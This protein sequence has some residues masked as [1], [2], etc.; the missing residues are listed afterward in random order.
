MRGRQL[1]RGECHRTN[2][3]L[4]ESLPYEPTFQLRCRHDDSRGA[5]P[6]NSHTCAVRSERLLCREP[7]V[8]SCLQGMSK[9]PGPSARPRRR[10]DHDERTKSRFGLKP[11]RLVA[12]TAYGSAANFDW[13]VNEKGI[14]PH[15]PV[16]DKSKRSFS[17]ITSVP[18]PA[19]EPATTR[20]GA[21]GAHHGVLRFLRE[22]GCRSNG[23]ELISVEPCPGRA[24]SRPTTGAK[25]P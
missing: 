2:T 4:R 12:D 24:G 9:L 1:G 18:P 23:V 15:I 22:G 3:H 10:P 8:K 7:Q 14:A 5:G 11:K 17:R 19:I 21:R 6:R 25:G 16:I 20:A 13:I